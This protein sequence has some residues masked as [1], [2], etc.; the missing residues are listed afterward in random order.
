MAASSE[1]EVDGGRVWLVKPA[2]NPGHWAP[3]CENHLAGI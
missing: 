3:H 1:G 2:L